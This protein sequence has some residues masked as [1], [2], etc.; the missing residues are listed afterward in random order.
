L[1]LTARQLPDDWQPRYDRR[2]HRGDHRTTS[3]PDPG[4]K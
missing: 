3:D 1:G 2:G 4:S